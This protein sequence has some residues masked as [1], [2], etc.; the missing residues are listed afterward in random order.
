[1]KKLLLLCLL[2]VTC[3]SKTVEPTYIRMSCTGDETF[4]SSI[5]PKKNVVRIKNFYLEISIQNSKPIFRKDDLPIIGL[6][7]DGL[8]GLLEHANDEDIRETM[9]DAEISITSNY[10]YAKPN[11]GGGSGSLTLNRYTGRVVVKDGYV[12]SGKGAADL[13]VIRGDY[14]CTK[15]DK[16]LF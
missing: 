13:T 7:G 4:N 9:S 5:Y 1:M 3:F 14:Q 10:R 16:K 8:M 11:S 6:G 15:L 12:F 2:P